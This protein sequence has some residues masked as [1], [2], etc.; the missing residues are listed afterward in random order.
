MS[1]FESSVPIGWRGYLS[2]G[3]CSPQCLRPPW[4]FWTEHWEEMPAQDSIPLG[5]A[6]LFS[7]PALSASRASFLAEGPALSGPLLSL[8]VSSFLGPGHQIWQICDKQSPE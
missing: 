1:I 3:N 5:P 7:V 4:N 2:D 8:A 6:H